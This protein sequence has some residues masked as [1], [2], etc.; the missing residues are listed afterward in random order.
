M[1]STRANSQRSKRAAPPAPASRHEVPDILR[2]LG[3]EHKYQARLLKLLE[4]Q[5]GLLNRRQAPDYEAMYGVMRYMTQY[6]D[7]FHHPKE[8]LL[9]EKIVQRD[10]SAK[11]RV[12]ELLEAHKDIIAKGARLLKAIERCRQK[13]DEAD[14]H[15][16]RKTA[17]AYI[18]ALRRHMDIE[19][20]H[21]FPR[22]EKVLRAQDWIEVDRRMKPILDPVF[23]G[24]VAAEFK[25]LH[26]AESTKAEPAP[27]GRLGSALIEAAALIETV[28]T[29]IAGASKMRQDFAQHNKNTLR[30][31]AEIWRELVRLMPIDQR[32]RTMGE[33]YERNLT[34]FAEF[35]NQM[36]DQWSE[37]WKT[38]WRPY[39]QG[40]GPYAPKLLRR[41]S[42]SSAASAE[43][44]SQ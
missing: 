24:E 34:T 20:L 8:D 23:G 5:V 19:Y 4:K 41:R 31:N 36:V 12:D 1:G 6:P 28:A 38:A 2:A 30:L 27:P 10:P 21:M 43:S 44:S 9:F 33:L 16:L 7:R 17:H 26:D 25:S 29:L 15:S 40:D 35:N 18:G 13:P 37:V 42:R 39:E 14:T 22:A 3:D 32:F 11:A